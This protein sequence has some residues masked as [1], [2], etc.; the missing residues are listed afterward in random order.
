MEGIQCCPVAGDDGKQVLSSGWWCGL[1]SVV[2]WLVLQGKLN[3]K[4]NMVGKNWVFSGAQL[5][6]PSIHKHTPEK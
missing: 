6:C 2:Q 3:T 4:E 5:Q 1:A